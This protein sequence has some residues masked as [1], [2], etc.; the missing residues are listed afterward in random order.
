MRIAIDA[1]GGDHAPKEIVLGAAKAVQHFQDIEIILF[2]NEQQI[3]SYLPAADRID[4]VHTDEVIEATDEPVRAVRRKKQS[5]LVLM[6]EE[7][8]Q[9][10]ADA[11]VSAGNT[12]ALMAAGLFIVG[13]IEG[14][15]RP[16]LAPTLPTLGGEGFVFLDVGANVDARPEHLVQYALMGSVYA[17]KAR[18]IAKPRIG[19][20]NVGTEDQKGND[21]TKRAFLLLQEANVN[22]I[23]NVEARDLLQG[24]A[25]VVVTDGFTGNVALK[26]IEGTALSVFSMLKK[27]LTSSFSSKLAAAV[28]KPKLLEMKRKMDY[29]EYGGAALFGLNAPVVKAHG[30]SDAT[31]IFHA[32]RQTREMVI[33]DMIGT[34]KQE[35]EH[36]HS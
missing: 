2:G 33:T 12:G 30:S 16:A 13:R 4:I 7:V 3:R 6:A 9:G 26:T 24:V 19:L 27:G 5:S 29:S 35:M 14:I 1:M 23:G 32:I 22:F 18:G 20:L 21:L 8:K 28:L 10:R 15:E 34:I 31:A 25:D 17:K 11:C 36:I